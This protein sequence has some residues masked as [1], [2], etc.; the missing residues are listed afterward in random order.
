MAPLTTDA[1]VA[2]KLAGTGGVSLVRHLGDWRS[3]VLPWKAGG[4]VTV[5]D[6]AFTAGGATFPAGTFILDGPKASEA[7]RALGLDVV[8]VAAA[9]NVKSHAVALP[10]IAYFHT[11][12]ETQ[13]EGWVR[14]AF[15]QMGVPYTYM[16]DQK[17]RTPGLLDR[18]DVVVFPHSG[19]GGMSLVNGRPMVGPPIPWRASKATPHLGKWDETDDM[20]PGMGLEGA[21]ALRK[22]VE[23]GGMLL[24][25]GATARLPLDLGFTPSITEFQSRTLGARGSV[26]RAQAVTTASPILYGYED[27]GTFPVYFNQTPLLQVAEAGRGPGAGGDDANAG[28][29]STIIQEQRRVQPRIILRFVDRADSIGVSGMMNN[30]QD[31]LG[32]AAVVDAPVGSGH[33][34]SFAIRPFWRWE[35]Q[36]T[37]ALALNAIANWNHLTVPLPAPTARRAVTT[38]AGG[39]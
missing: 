31:L 10:R 38:E 1:K 2:G 7:A 18:Y 23:R 17:L 37:F 19:Q 26:V 14:Y 30:P 27:R 6:S 33:V 15:D 22:F 32:K 11:W 12:Q 34:V 13:N 3:A 24:V 36:G 29:D 28:V 9:P 8:A 4:K 16:A 39:R 21:A 25:E 20:R 35:S 5:A